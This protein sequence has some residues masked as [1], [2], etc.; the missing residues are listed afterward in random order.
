MARPSGIFLIF[1]FFG[2]LTSDAPGR[3][4][5]PPRD[6]SSAP[7]RVIK[8]PVRAITTQEVSG[9]A[10]ADRAA[11][12][13]SPGAEDELPEGPNGFDV[14]GDDS[15]AIT[16]PLRNSVS[17][18]DS[19]GKFREAWK[20]G[21][22]A[23]SVTA[24]PNGNI[25][26]R[27]ARTGQVHVFDAK[28]QEQ[29]EER[30]EI[31]KSPEAKILSGTSGTVQ[32]PAVGGFQGGL[33]TIQF[34]KPG[35]T[36]VSLENLGTDSEG[37]TYVALEATTGATGDDINVSKHVRRYSADGKIIAEIANLP[38]DYYIPPVNELR[39]HRALVYQ[40]FATKSE[41]R[42]NIWNTNQRD[43]RSLR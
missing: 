39:V 18:F 25:L 8:I 29:P 28:G 23:D 40:L 15:L 16:D 36:L 22:S 11:L 30:A 26:I 35:S 3:Q 12:L 24:V 38:L 32:R 34:E 13:V 6:A 7:T 41:V 33:L 31:P 21:F 42:I 37:D 14:L 5:G 27:E 9:T 43:F 2:F 17:F 1:L 20:I 4:T 10:N 19:Q